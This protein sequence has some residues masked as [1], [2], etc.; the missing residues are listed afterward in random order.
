ML[1]IQ[2]AQIPLEI[3]DLDTCFSPQ[4]L[5]LIEHEW[6]KD[7]NE[8]KL[9]KGRLYE[10]V[11]IWVHKAFWMLQNETYFQRIHFASPRKPVSSRAHTNTHRWLPSRSWSFLCWNTLEPRRWNTRSS[12][13]G[14]SSSQAGRK[15]LWAD[16]N[17]TQGPNGQKGSRKTGFEGGKIYHL[18]MQISVATK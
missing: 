13:L 10:L 2:A 3:F 12:S 14:V 7:T 1:G 18:T 16:R 8:V 5:H 6:T 9:I 11:L 4:L 15:T 17:P